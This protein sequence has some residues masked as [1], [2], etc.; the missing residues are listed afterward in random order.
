MTME[1]NEDQWNKLKKHA[2]NAYI[3]E[4]VL[5]CNESYPY[6]EIKLGKE[7]LRKALEDAVEKAKNDGF[8][9]RGAVQLY[10]DILILFGEEFQT[11]PQYS[12]IREILDNHA[13]LGQLE[14]TTLLYHE[15]TRYL[16]EVHGEQDENLKASILKFQ[17]INIEH[18]NVQWNTY[19]SN[20]DVL[21]N[22]LFPK[23][24]QHIKQDNI[25][26]VIQFGIEKSSQYGIEDANHAAFL[27][28]IMFLLG[29]EFDQDIFLPHLNT[30]L[31][32]QYYTDIDSLIIEM[33]KQAKDYLKVF[34]Q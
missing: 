15:V 22:S 24:Y 34:L 16:N 27:T 21:L 13:H 5:H 26:K 33:E 17:N 1:L 29:H 8:D 7:G 3:D 25:K 10:I 19:K 23:K 32:K 30:R 28:L 31:F 9:Q 4:L 14:K 11:D 6:L 12:W 20:V 18:L 2:F